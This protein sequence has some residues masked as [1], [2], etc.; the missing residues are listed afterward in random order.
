M[1][2]KQKKSEKKKVSKGLILGIVGIILLFLSYLSI[3][4]ILCFYLSL[5][6]II[7]LVAGIS[8]SIKEVNKK[9]KNLGIVLNTISLVFSVLIIL[10]WLFTI[11]SYPYP[12][13]DCFKSLD[14]LSI[15]TENT[16]YTN[17]DGKLTLKLEV[18]RGPEPLKLEGIVIT[19]YGEGTSETSEIRDVPERMKTQTYLIGTNLSQI[20]SMEISPIFEENVFCDPIDRKEISEC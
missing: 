10:L 14:Q 20:D 8:L 19:T 7:I 11:C 16:C 3:C 12:P 4:T 15:V 18:K 9:G 17:V 2:K 6:T 1:P 5:F 13:S